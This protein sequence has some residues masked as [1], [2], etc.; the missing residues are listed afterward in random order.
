MGKIS[1]EMKRSKGVPDWRPR[2]EMIGL[3]VIAGASPNGK[4]AAFG[5]AICRFESYR[6]SQ[7]RRLAGELNPEASG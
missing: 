6:P 2:I 5:A 1:P 4:A 3:R 7:T